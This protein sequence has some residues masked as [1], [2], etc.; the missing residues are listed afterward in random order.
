[1]KEEEGEW[2]E[3]GGKGEIFEREREREEI[4]E[5]SPLHT[6]K[7]KEKTQQPIFFLP[8]TPHARFFSR[9]PFFSLSPI[10]CE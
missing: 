4:L 5:R 6:K 3:E 7:R 10:L 2:K 9:F 1:M 8:P